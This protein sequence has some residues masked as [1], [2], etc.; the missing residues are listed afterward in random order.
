MV[1][2]DGAR[3]RSVDDVALAFLEPD[4]DFTPAEVG[5]WHQIIATPGVRKIMILTVGPLRSEPDNRRVTTELLKQHDV[6]LVA[7][8]DHRRNVGLIG[9]F[10][11]LG[12]TITGYP[13]T[14]LEDAAR[15]VAA[16]PELVAPI[17]RAA[18]ALRAESPAAVGLD[19]SE[20]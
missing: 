13:W 20:G 4:R 6:R 3:F 5:R 19:P 12:V 10:S 1:G 17:L 14:R 18:L 16:R 9:M 7:V 2:V 15:D 11:W 8:T